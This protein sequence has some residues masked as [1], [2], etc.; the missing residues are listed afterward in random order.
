MIVVDDNRLDRELAKDALGPRVRLEVCESGERALESL[1]REPADL[2][3]CDLTMPG[4]SGLD[5]LQRIRREHP[6]TDFLV[7][8]GHASVESAVA[9][10]TRSISRTHC[11][12]LP[13]GGTAPARC[14]SSRCVCALMSPGRT[15]APGRSMTVVSD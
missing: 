3:L 13:A 8:T 1:R 9:A 10:R 7:L 5:L 12:K 2:V 6:G 4:L 15:T 11:T 14:E